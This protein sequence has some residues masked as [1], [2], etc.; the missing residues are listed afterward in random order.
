MSTQ[1]KALPFFGG[2]LSGFDP[3]DTGIFESTGAGTYDTNYANCALQINTASTGTSPTW[4][5]ASTFWIRFFLKFGIPI[6]GFP[7]FSIVNL[8][9]TGTVVGQIQ[10]AWG[11]LGT[12][13]AVNTYTLQS[14]SLKLIWSGSP[15]VFWFP[16]FNVF[17]LNVV[18]NTASGSAALYSNG[19]ITAAQGTGL[20]HSAWAGVDQVQMLGASTSVGGPIYF[21]EIICDTTSTVGRRLRT[22]RLNTNSATNTG[23]TG[24]VT[25]I[26][27][28]PTTDNSP[29]TAAASNLT[30]TFFENGLALGNITPLARGVSARMKREDS[31]GPQHI[32]MVIRA[33]ATNFPS[34]NIPASLGYQAAFNSW[35]TNPHTS[36]NW[37]ATNASAAENGVKSLT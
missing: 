26:N 21:S 28:I 36:A 30:S 16:G 29:L 35:T 1:I 15:G 4:P 19:S 3:S 6:S 17:D 27:E 8:L 23:W 31:S 33:G 13:F 7:V 14:G 2:T 37:T 34:T 25:N 9:H 12:G 20:N 11:G 32:A 22:D 24:S 10:L 18:G 5:A